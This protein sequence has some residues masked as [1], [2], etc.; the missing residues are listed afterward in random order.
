LRQ[1]TGPKAVEA[2]ISEWG[3]VPVIFITGTPDECEPCDPP[4]RV[5]GKPIHEPTL[6]AAFRQMAPV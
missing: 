5:F 1:G 3:L 4:H 2:I 6:A